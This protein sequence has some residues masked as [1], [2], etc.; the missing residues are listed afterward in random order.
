MC[1]LLGEM[2]A[3][4]AAVSHGWPGSEEFPTYE[5]WTSELAAKSADL[6]AYDPDDEVSYAAAQAALHWIADHL[7]GLW[8]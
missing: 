4:L 3:Q 8:D 6:L 2:L 7:G 5:S 1:R